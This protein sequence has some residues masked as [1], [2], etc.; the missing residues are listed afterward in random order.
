[1][2]ETLQVLVVEDSE[3]DCELLLRALRAG[4]YDPQWERVDS[5]QSLSRALKIGHWDIVL[6]DYTMP[7]FRGTDALAIIR[8][9]DPDTP[10]IFV[11]GTIGEEVA[12]QAM[13]AGAQD[14]IMKGNLKRLVPAVD[15][16]LHEAEVRRDHVRVEAAQRVAEERFRNVL[17]MAPDAV[18][19]IDGGQRIVT[20]NRGA[21]QI[22]GYRWGEVIDQPLDMLLPERYRGAHQAHVAEFGRSTQSARSMAERMEVR[23]LRKNGQEFPAEASIS[24]LTDEI[25]TTFTVILRDITERKRT[26]Q[27][28]R[29]LQTTIQAAGQASDM[30]AALA[31]ALNMIC[32]ATECVLAQAW[33]PCADGGTLECSPAWH[34]SVPGGEAFRATSV[35]CAYKEGDGLPGRTWATRAVQ[36]TEDAA[37]EFDP[38]R[39]KVARQVGL[40]AA[41]GVPV[42]AGENVVAILELFPGEARAKDDRLVHLLRGVASQLGAV[43]QRKRAEDR[44]NYLAHYDVVTGLPNRVLLADRLK[45]AIAEANRHR[46]PLGVMLLDLDRFKTINDS[47][48]HGVGDLLLQRVAERLVRCVREGDTVARLSGDEFTILV[49][50]LAGAND[51]IPVARKVLD[52]LAKPF[53]VSGHELF[54][55]GSLGMT[56]YPADADDADA[57]LRNADIAMYR[58]KERG[59]DGFEF[60]SAEMGGKANERLSMETALRH[61]LDHDEFVLHYQPV[62]DLESGRIL[63]VE[64]LVRWRHP[65]RGLVPP[66]EFIP[67]AE[68]TGLIS[69]LGDWVLSAACQQYADW[70]LPAGTGLRL[71]VNVSPP[72]FQDLDLP[73]R[74]VAIANRTGFDLSLLELEITESC[75]MQNRDSTI[76]VLERLSAMQVQFVIDDFGTGYSNVSY[77][78][79]LP[80]ARVK[81]DRS[82]IRDIPQDAN[83]VALASAIISMAQALGLEV[84][85]EGVET[86]AQLKMLKDRR[87]GAGQG[88]LFSRPV[89]S[90]EVARLLTQGDIDLGGN[91]C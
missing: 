65:K 9:R 19:C 70:G 91:G 82:F 83:D 77:L 8:E 45:Q 53:H 68:E 61:A 46:R 1:M 71:A 40:G 7:S 87:C 58:A 32:Q 16:E 66:L 43:I 42:L 84:T 23:G 36:W 64:A 27:E 74:I 11:S 22:F 59:G 26:E 63:G 50:D 90:E 67:V 20:F 48:G 72:Q 60:F 44:L 34:C 31:V 15:R 6:A 81:I 52:A 33:V 75:L 30:H 14:Y 79:S 54:A 37:R 2:I 3:D 73:S 85:A 17:T 49:V 57:L 24:R 78:K 21:E 62:V 18:I 5:A 4:G 80:I 35:S 12:V 13:R 55:T 47:L 86:R 69:R 38:H 89:P 29:L 76:A 10:F 88:F 39:E 51:A 28:L 41:V 25:G 56:L